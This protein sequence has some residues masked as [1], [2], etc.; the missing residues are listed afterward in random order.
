MPDE[1][2]FNAATMRS[3]FLSK[4]L[5]P[6]RD[7]DDECGYPKVV[8]AE[9]YRLLY[10]REGIA[11]RVVNVYPFESWALDPEIYETEDADETEFEAAWDALNDDYHCY[12]YLQRVDEL[13]GIGHYGVLLLGLGDGAELSDP[14]DGMDEAG[15]QVGKPQHSLLYLRVFDESLVDIASYETDPTNPRFG[16]PTAYNITFHDP[17]LQESGAVATQDQTTKRVHWHRVLHVAD[18]RKSSEVFGVPRM[19]PVYNRLYDLRK[20][21][22]G[23]AEMFWKGAFPGYSFEVSPE[24]GEVEI[25]SAALRTEFESYSNGLQRYLALT[26]VQAKSLA[27]QVADPQAHVDAQLQAIAIT[28]GVPMRVFM[29]SE[30]AQLA[31]GQD[32]RAWNRRVDRR[33]EKYLTPMLIRPYIDRLI[34]LGVLPEP[35]EYTVRFPDLAAPTDEDRAGIAL[36]RT[37]AFAKYVGGGVDTLIPPMEFLTIVCGMRDEEAE[38]IMEAAYDHI[39]SANPGAD[40]KLI[41]PPREPSGAAPPDTPPPAAPAAV[42]LEPQEEPAPPVGN[43]GD[44]GS[45]N[46]PHGK[47]GGKKGAAAAAGPTSENLGPSIAQRDYDGS[48]VGGRAE[49]PDGMTGEGLGKTVRHTR[50]ESVG[51]LRVGVTTSDGRGFADVNGA[52]NTWDGLVEEGGRESFSPADVRKVYAF[53]G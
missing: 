41:V 51:E 46:Y 25:D 16:F 50:S 9:Q 53:Q 30:Q 42:E 5:D 13:S 18:N 23:S 3:Q 22:G 37:E 38:A 29:G 49:T 10:D 2:A 48:F 47:G 40:P 17:N 44:R 45:K 26:G 39:L 11:E 27:P 43:H 31:S 52:G 4:L 35:V 28:L 8:T 20:L 6:R 19:R 1:M 15:Q 21:L 7:I 14:V 33:R 32:A 36:R 34:T 12:A 24:M